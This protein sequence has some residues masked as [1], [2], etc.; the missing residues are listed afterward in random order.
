MVRAV[1]TVLCL[2]AIAKLFLCSFSLRNIIICFVTAL[3]DAE[4]DKKGETWR[5]RSDSL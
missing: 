5:A 4:A 1:L 2:L 3:A